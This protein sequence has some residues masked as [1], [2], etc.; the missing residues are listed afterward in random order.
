MHAL[1]V[2]VFNAAI[3]FDEHP[4]AAMQHDVIAQGIFKSIE[5]LDKSL[6]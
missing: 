6:G 4:L 1:L 2:F 3:V 5:E